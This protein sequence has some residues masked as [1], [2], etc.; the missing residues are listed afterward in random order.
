M[1]QVREYNDDL[2]DFFGKN[3][4]GEDHKEAMKI[5]AKGMFARYMVEMMQ[6]D[7]A[8]TNDMMATY[9]RILEPTSL[10]E[11]AAVRTFADYLVFRLSNSGVEYA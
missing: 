8:L 2:Q 11:T 6:I 9:S 10:P 5:K 4:D 1:L 7:R 3:M